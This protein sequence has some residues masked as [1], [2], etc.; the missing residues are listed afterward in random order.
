MISKQLPII[1]WCESFKDLLARCIGVKYIPLSYVI[2]DDATVPA[3]CPDRANDQPYSQS[4]GSIEADLVARASHTHNLYRD[5]N[6]SVYYKLEEATRGTSYADSIK[7]FQAR[8]D[9]RG[10][11]LVLVAQYAGNDKYEAE[12]KKQTDILHNRKWK[13]QSNFK[14]ESFVQQHRQAYV[15]LQACSQHVEFQLPNEHTGVGYILDAIENADPG[16]QAAMARILD[17]KG[18]HGK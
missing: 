9:G 12:I 5:D 10:A 2:R 18:E 11:F 8:K 17:D 4:H 13:G 7:P 15:S 14:L 6:A 1:R 16:L 3:T